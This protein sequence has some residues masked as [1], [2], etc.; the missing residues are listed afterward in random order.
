MRESQQQIDIVLTMVPWS[1]QCVIPFTKGTKKMLKELF[2]L[3][4]V[5]VCMT[6]AVDVKICTM[7]LWSLAVLLNFQGQ[8]HVVV[9]VVNCA[10][11]M[12]KLQ[13]MIN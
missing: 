11:Y 8:L 7:I 3:L 12:M 13:E 10:Q 4:Q 1:T 2:S 5:T 6:V 9:A